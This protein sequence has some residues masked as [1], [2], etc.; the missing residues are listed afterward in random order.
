M[1]RPALLVVWVLE[2]WLVLLLALAALAWIWSGSE[3]S[4]AQALPWAK[5]F[6][7][8]GQQL[9]ADD[10]RGSVRAGGQVARLRWSMAG[11]S[12]EG[13]GVNVRWDFWDLVSGRIRLPQLEAD[14]LVVEDR[15]PAS[16]EPL[17][18]LVLPLPFDVALAIGR[19]RWIGPPEVLVTGI[20]GQYA[21]DGTHHALRLD[22]AQFA[23]GRYRGKVSLLARSPLTLAL[24]ASGR[25]EVPLG[26]QKML[27]DAQAALRGPLARSAGPLQL[28]ADLQPAAGSPGATGGAQGMRAHV[29]ARILPWAAQPVVDAQARYRQLDLS[30]LWPDAPS[31]RLDGSAQVQPRGTQW[32]ARVDLDNTLPGPWDKGQLPVSQARAVVAHTPGGWVIESLQAQAAGGSFDLQGRLAEGTG[33]A[34]ARTWQARAQWT[35]INPALAYSPLAAAR[36]GGNLDA[37]SDGRSLAFNMAVQPAGVQPP[38]SPLAGL[39][40]QRATARGSWADGWLRLAEMQLQT[41]DAW[42]QGPLDIQPASRSANGQ[43]QITLPGAQGRLEGKIAPRE[44]TGSLALDISDTTRL[45]A[46]LRRLPV[47]A[48]PLALPDLRGKADLALQWQGGWQD[49]QDGLGSNTRVQATLR[50]PALALHTSPAGTEPALRVRDTRITLA[51]TAAN[52]TLASSG[53]LLR[54]A[55]TVTLQAQARG[56][57]L[58]QGDWRFA[59]DTLRADLN[60]PRDGGRWSLSLLGP[61]GL[62]WRMLPGGGS[63]QT[64]AAQARLTGPLPGAATL[65]AQPVTWNL[66]ARGSLA[67][68]GQLRDLPLSWLAL[69]GGTPL[70]TLGLSGNM[71][72]DAAW[73]LAMT[74][75][76]RARA[77]LMRRSGDI[78]VLA[79]SLP[80]SLEAGTAVDAGV[81]NARIDLAVDD[82]NVSAA[83]RWDSERAGTAKADLGTRLTRDADGWSWPTLAPLTGTVQAR[84]PQVGVWSLLA[85]PGWRMRGTLDANLV[86]TGHRQAPDWSGQIRADGLALRSV[87]DGI[88][89]GNGRLRARMQGQR[90]FIEEFTLQGA[91][92]AA[93]GSL[94]ATGYALWVPASEGDGGAVSRVR[95]DLDATARALRVSARA[96]QRLVVSG[97]LQ[98]RLRDARLDVQGALSVDQ[99]LFVLPEETAPR[100]GDDVVVL[101]RRARE[102]DTPATVPVGSATPIAAPGAAGRTVQTTLALAVDLGPEFRVQGRGI[103]TRLAGKLQLRGNPGELPRLNGEVR[104]RQGTYRA[105]GQRLDIEQGVLRFT[106]SL[107]NPSLD[108]LALRPNLSQRVGVQ[109]T[110]TASAPRVRLFSEPEMPE[111]E[112]LAWLVLGRSG[113][114]GGAEAAVLQ[115]AALALLGRNGQGLSGGLANALGLDEVSIAGAA[116]RNDGTTTS[117]TVTLGKRI[118]RDF[119]VAY[120]RSLAGTLGTISIF[121]DLSRR[122]T[123]RASTGEQS[124]I[125]LIFTIRYD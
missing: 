87:V 81:R 64:G 25:V 59:V 26:P 106:G 60:G 67:S 46:W 31:T 63:L 45:S 71:V 56:G 57:R 65:E 94:E 91:G 20:R 30:V 50:I 44:G 76:L 15:R 21:Y 39:R 111:A 28:T 37:R 73:E 17:T 7:P 12:V 27:L 52:L 11:L 124:T 72:F 118:S 113:A 123:L 55:Q 79:E 122:F 18:E 19:L 48:Q 102:G 5:R 66:G 23:Q 78:R 74:E 51:G 121:Y 108:I 42:V 80:G 10:V 53:Q 86:L 90:L 35:G 110:G 34:L 40:L 104:T 38:A 107:D 33:S 100:L 14:E 97:T 62:D 119:Y 125:D 105:Y 3:G 116:T 109:I 84:L 13:R 95:I 85:P 92:G 69:L 8:V 6:L 47:R 77:S 117:A 89:F 75:T 43:V 36:L 120:E 93:G 82:L 2:L 68:Q 16:P 4:L 9:V 101:P 96:D 58:P 115:Q 49:L 88:E 112:K 114:N 61:L 1:R 32:Q 41:D 103:V 24:D 70:A 83:L 22:S 54:D 29:T 99:A 98:A